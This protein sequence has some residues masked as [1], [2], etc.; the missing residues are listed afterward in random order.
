MIGALTVLVLGIG[1]LWWR[2]RTARRLALLVEGDGQLAPDTMSDVDVGLGAVETAL[3]M[4]RGEYCQRDAP[5][6]RP[7][8]ASAMMRIPSGMR[9]VGIEL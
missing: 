8:M 6:D 9:D 1:Y 4:G 3:R 5:M 2:Q 7:S